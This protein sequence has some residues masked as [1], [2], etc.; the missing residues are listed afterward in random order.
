MAGFLRMR[1]DDV[2]EV[3]CIAFTSLR[4]IRFSESEVVASNFTSGVQGATVK[5]GERVKPNESEGKLGEPRERAV[6]PFDMSQFV[7]E[8]ITEFFVWPLRG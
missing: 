4:I 8:D 3:S 7:A 2:E 5:P 6:I 1:G